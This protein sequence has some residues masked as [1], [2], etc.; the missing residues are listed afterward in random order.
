MLYISGEFYETTQVDSMSLQAR[1]WTLHSNNELLEY[2][3]I[4]KCFKPLK[5]NPIQGIFGTLALLLVIC[6]QES[7]FAATHMPVHCLR[8]LK[9]CCFA[10]PVSRLLF[11]LLLLWSVGVCCDVCVSC[12]RSPSQST[13]F[14]NPPSLLSSLLIPSSSQHPKSPTPPK[15]HGFRLLVLKLVSLKVVWALPQI[16]LQ[17]KVITEAEPGRKPF[18]FSSFLC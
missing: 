9:V 13:T 18:V 17:L 11:L 3:L 8:T 2:C 10:V 5:N 4:L 12:C 6:D 1:L 15:A 14:C 16:R 7:A